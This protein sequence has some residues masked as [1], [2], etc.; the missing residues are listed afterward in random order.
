MV[1]LP[2]ILSPFIVHT[3]VHDV[4][5]LKKYALERGWSERF[6]IQWI[7]LTDAIPHALFLTASKAFDALVNFII[8]RF[9]DSYLDTRLSANA[10]MQALGYTI[11]LLPSFMGSYGFDLIK[12]CQTIEKKL[13]L[14]S[15]I[16]QLKK[17][18]EEDSFSYEKAQKEK[19][20][21]LELLDT[22]QKDLSTLGHLR[23]DSLAT[24]SKNFN[25]FKH[26]WK[27]LGLPLCSIAASLLPDQALVRAQLSHALPHA[28]SLFSKHVETS[29]TSSSTDSE[30]EMLFG[31]MHGDFTGCLAPPPSP[32]AF[33]K[34][35]LQFIQS[36]RTNPLLKE[37]FQGASQ[38]LQ[39]LTKRLKALVELEKLKQTTPASDFTAFGKQFTEKLVAHQTLTLA[40]QSYLTFHLEKRNGKRWIRGEVINHGMTGIG[41]VGEE[42]SFID[43]QGRMRINPVQ[44]L[45]PA[46]LEEV[47]NSFFWK[48]LLELQ[49]SKDS[50][51][52]D[53]Q[54]GIQ[55]FNTVL[56][57]NWP[58]GVGS[59]TDEEVKLQYSV[60]GQFNSLKS[61]IKDILGPEHGTPFL[62]CLYEAILEDYAEAGI[63]E[64]NAFALKETAAHFAR[65]LL[66][67]IPEKHA[68][69]QAISRKIDCVNQAIR[70]FEVNQ[71]QAYEQGQMDTTA[72]SHGETSLEMRFIPS[73]SETIVLNPPR[74]GVL[75][76]LLYFLD[77]KSQ[78]RS[79][80]DK[81]CI[82]R[83]GLEVLPS[84][85]DPFWETQEA[86]RVIDLVKILSS[87]FKK[88][89]L[90]EQDSSIEPA[91]INPDDAALLFK[92]YAILFKLYAARCPSDALSQFY[93]N[94]VQQVL[95]S[96][97]TFLLRPHH[98]DRVAELRQ[99]IDYLSHQEL[100]EDFDNLDMMEITADSTNDLKKYPHL[101][102]IYQQLQNDPQLKQIVKDKLMR[103]E[104]EQALSELDYVG[105]IYEKLAYTFSFKGH[106]I[107]HYHD[108][109]ETWAE[110]FSL[111]GV[112]MKGDQ[113]SHFSRSNRY[114]SKNKKFSE[115]YEAYCSIAPD[116]F[117]TFP[118]NPQG[119]RGKEMNKACQSNL[120]LET[121]P[122]FDAEGVE[123]LLP[124]LKKEHR[125]EGRDKRNENQHLLHSEGLEVAGERL[126]FYEVQSLLSLTTYKDLSVD[127]I[128]KHFDRFFHRMKNPTFQTLFDALLTQVFYQK[129]GTHN[130]LSYAIDHQ[131]GQISQLL[132]F[133]QKRRIDAKKYGWNQLTTYLFWVE[134]LVLSYLLRGR[135][136]GINVNA[137]YQNYLDHIRLFYE[138]EENPEL[139][140]PLSSRLVALAPYFENTTK[141][142]S[143][144][145]FIENLLGAAGTSDEAPLRERRAFDHAHMLFNGKL[146]KSVDG[147]HR[148][149]VNTPSFQGRYSLCSGARI[150][151][152]GKRLFGDL[153]YF[154]SEDERH[155]LLF[156]KGD[157]LPSYFCNGRDIELLE[158]GT[159]TGLT[160]VTEYQKLPIAGYFMRM[161]GETGLHLW[162]NRSN[163]VVRADFV[164][165]N[166]SFHFEPDASQRGQG[167]WVSSRHPGY[168]LDSQFQSDH[169]EPCSHYLV[170]RNQNGQ[171][172][173]YTL[174][175]P[176]SQ[177]EEKVIENLLMMPNHTVVAHARGETLLVYPLDDNQDIDFSHLNHEELLYG[178]YLALRGRNFEK[179]ALFLKRWEM[180]QP[181]HSEKTK[182]ILGY[183]LGMPPMLDQNPQTVAIRLRLIWSLLKDPFLSLEDDTRNAFVAFL[184]QDLNRY[185]TQK[186]HVHPFALSSELLEEIEKGKGDKYAELVEGHLAHLGL[187]MKNAHPTVDLG[188]I[189]W[190]RFHFSLNALRT[191]APVDFSMLPGQA[192]LE[193]FFYYY[194]LAQ[195]L[196]MDDPKRTE[197]TYLLE[198]CQNDPSH[199]VQFRRKILQAVL[200]R[201]YVFPTAEE[202][203]LRAKCQKK[204]VIL[205][206]LYNRAHALP[207]IDY[208]SNALSLFLEMAP[209][210]ITTYLKNKDNH[211]T[212]SAKAGYIISQISTFIWIWR[213]STSYFGP[214]ALLLSQNIYFN[215]FFRGLL[216]LV[217][218]AIS[219]ELL[220]GKYFS[221]FTPKRISLFF[222]GLSLKNWFWT[223]ETSRLFPQPTTP[224]EIFSPVV[225]FQSQLGAPIDSLLNLQDPSAPYLYALPRDVTESLEA[226]DDI[227]RTFTSSSQER[228]PCVQ[229]QHDAFLEGVK[230]KRAEVEKLQ[231]APEYRVNP[232][233]MEAFL[234]ELQKQKI[235]FENDSRQKES[236]I[237]R[238]AHYYPDQMHVEA[239]GNLLTPLSLEELIVAFG[240]NDNARILRSNPSLTEAEFTR[241]KQL[242]GEYLVAKTRAKQLES[243]CEKLQQAIALKE[244]MRETHSHYWLTNAY[245]RYT[246]R[247]HDPVK[248]R[249]EMD[250][251]LKDVT[252]LLQTKRAFIGSQ[253]PELLVFEYFMGITVRDN[254]IAFLERLVKT[255]GD[256]AA[257]KDLLEEAHTGFGKSKVAV[258][259]W[260]Y[261]TSQAGRVAMITVPET[262]L[263]EMRVH[264]RKVLGKC[265]D[266]TIATIDFDRT[267]A[268]DIRYLTY[269][270][271]VFEEAEK[272]GKP[273]VLSIH[274]L[275]GLSVLK[276]KETYFKILH[277][278]TPPEHLKQL[279]EIRRTLAT[280][281]SNFVDEA[282]DCF[283]IRYFYDYSIGRKKHLER[284]YMETTR[285]LFQTFIQNEA[286]LQE[287]DF[288]FLRSGEIPTDQTYIDRDT[289]EAKILPE[290]I[291][292]TLAQFKVPAAHQEGARKSLSGGYGP[293]CE[294]Y[295]QTLSEKELKRFSIWRKQLVIY[296]RQS[297]SCRWNERYK[298]GED[299]IA[300]PA[301]HGQLIPRSQFSSLDLILNF[302]YQANMRTPF[303]YRDV[304]TYIEEL[305]VSLASKS[306]T[307]FEAS[308]QFQL[309][310][311]FSEN[312]RNFPAL[313]DVREEHKHELL[314]EINR[315]PENRLLFT[316]G[317]V[318]PKL[319]YYPKKIVSYPQLM[320]Q[321]VDHTQ[322]ASGA[323]IENVPKRFKLNFDPKTIF[324][325]LL[326]LW[327][328]SQDRVHTI[329][330][331]EGP[332]LVEHLFRNFNDGFNVLIDIAGYLRG[333]ASNQALAQEILRVTAWRR[334]SIEAVG[335]IDEQGRN[336]LLKRGQ[337][338]AVLRENASI[339]RD[340]IFMVYSQEAVIGF[341]IDLS[342]DARALVTAGRLTPRDFFMQGVGRLRGLNTGML[343][344]FITIQDEMEYIRTQL[345]LSPNHQMQFKDLFL[346]F[347]DLGGKQSG[348]E[349]FDVMYH[350]WMA[351]IEELFFGKDLQISEEE[352]QRLFRQLEDFFC[353]ETFSHPIESLR[354]T[355]EQ[356]NTDEAIENAL[357]RLL[358]T[359]EA[360]VKKHPELKS[361]Y[362]PAHLKEI[363]SSEFEKARLRRNYMQST[364]AELQLSFSEQEEEREQD[365]D[366]EQIDNLSRGEML[367][368]NPLEPEDLGPY[369]Q[370][371]QYRPVAPFHEASQDFVK[372][373][374]LCTDQFF[375]IAAGSPD[376]YQT[377]M[378]PA[379]YSLVI[380]DRFT[381]KYQLVLLDLHGA[382]CILKQMEEETT[383]RSNDRSFYLIGNDQM[384]PLAQNGR[385]KWKRE[386]DP[387]LRKLFFQARPY[388][389]NLLLNGEDRQ[390]LEKR[391][392][393]YVEAFFDSVDQRFTKPWPHY[394][395]KLNDLI[396]II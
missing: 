114:S 4:H 296:L 254:Q 234:A 242:I 160:L 350:E 187:K 103:Y 237:L 334:P 203:I 268:N 357:K 123:N 171:R 167:R 346:Y 263:E 159:R 60:G 252:L 351:Q 11:S 139:L 280:K 158:N 306:Q 65:R 137:A 177:E 238:I 369:D 27:R 329:P 246:G 199:E 388:T 119:L 80:R 184:T 235:P 7:T 381:K 365:V 226:L 91:A 47:Q 197:L 328:K 126:P 48:V 216:Y 34:Y 359:F 192:F 285:E 14:S 370:L 297:L 45:K 102:F 339:D 110:F 182:N 229:R 112:R 348:D 157:A 261:L 207:P 99:C 382:H 393:E 209:S 371:S 76:Q 355:R 330:K 37:T 253:N 168:Y 64:R 208:L 302:T 298:L 141:N 258:P 283:Y 142:Q 219:D 147:I 363:L 274:S 293:E 213:L 155:G 49:Q 271:H 260:L 185:H 286:L 217:Y 288:D 154:Q 85:Q 303:T 50:S 243:A 79:T 390:D 300:Y 181:L 44:I 267:K 347:F 266:Q 210:F 10:A 379:R 164:K 354:S 248:D 127:L 295:F 327:Q 214:F 265:F 385:D 176:F 193:N 282:S 183:M 322:G 77:E 124:I 367:N 201:P 35:I 8:L 29:S 315:N 66:K 56:L 118:Y 325:N 115:D 174:D 313:I 194:H 178:I 307:E 273:I 148:R 143:F 259:L 374:L 362:D 251:L 86:F 221:H 74:S 361:E 195:T 284:T 162:K 32:E 30:L 299:R 332:A 190:N 304:H 6:S 335:F 58:G 349:A 188:S 84:I 230:Q 82:L 360:L 396:H 256:P 68:L 61:V 294:A 101:E 224:K 204:D 12:M 375:T 276:H 249:F 62:L 344:T 130:L 170:L 150:L 340:K 312:I 19:A 179:A 15:H 23:L 106:E 189:R 337:T 108:F 149:I 215:V 289:Y 301:R 41:L 55:H 52:E 87:D 331:L 92:S 165:L 3:P 38:E 233:R 389:G 338:K 392:R 366:S 308:S 353:Q 109:Q 212:I 211:Q 352:R 394:R 323:L 135:A 326:I 342:R 223:S 17:R 89:Q 146:E 202:L 117:G 151:N 71:T 98:P 128:V 95:R 345:K 138:R 21:L 145:T 262:L 161:A 129:S 72:L 152:H 391:G 26:H 33:S 236:L 310:Q 93:F 54:W 319:E 247:Y 239:Q 198:A 166:L 140:A 1:K 97:S 63:N 70:A 144:F 36:M 2:S 40:S 31:A 125:F 317:Y 13:T 28:D 200:N 172:I 232:D 373:D 122:G 22:F 333:F 78:A 341:D 241:L 96:D 386:L 245:H 305:M 105:K 116:E 380:Y 376:L 320:C 153:Q 321:R 53:L 314:A 9:E 88:M 113:M 46:P 163:E 358:S 240:R 131:P 180:E 57:P 24:F 270:N 132:E 67:S 39:G 278:G 218:K 364:E 250:A 75:R 264:L 120:F 316:E 191:P 51:G 220:T 309:F 287:I 290:L 25:W 186:N 156:K 133:I 277:E 383:P 225:T 196:P 228:E 69:V 136:E 336:M 318:L 121:Y 5:Q 227:Q 272:Q 343:A 169:F 372:S 269:L 292:M 73:T 16:Q 384:N 43:A 255:K 356:L 291:Q 377:T 281:V 81:M 231:D 59:H 107:T 205:L 395:S 368:F 104:D 324:K 206:N 244:R 90:K 83:R 257:L 20:L 94:R 18:L 42:A 279:D 275:H 111:F 222:K 175:A 134:G 173:V 100:E 311:T 387:A 378:K